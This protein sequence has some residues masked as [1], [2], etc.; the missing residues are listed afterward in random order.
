MSDIVS[1]E[2]GRFTCPPTL[3][4]VEK[5]AE[6]GEVLVGEDF[7]RE[8]ALAFLAAYQWPPGLIRAAH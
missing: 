1:R 2:N 6:S 5:L 4:T 8:F 7:S 3:E